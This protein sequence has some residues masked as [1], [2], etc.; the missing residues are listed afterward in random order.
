MRLDKFLTEMN[1]GSRSE[2]KLLLKKK[3]V[4]V[5]QITVTKPE[6]KV[7]PD[8]DVITYQNKVLS[9]EKY[10]YFMLHKPAG[11]VSATDDNTCETVIDL[12]KAEPY[13]NL[14]P[15][16]RLDKDTEGLLLIT[17]DGKFAHELLSPK[18][19]VTKCYYAVIDKPVT[20]IE[21]AAFQQGIDINDEKVTLPAELKAL[22]EEEN[23]QYLAK[24]D[25]ACFQSLHGF[26]TLVT[27][28][29]GR[30]HQVKRMFAAFQQEV[31]YLK[32]ISMGELALDDTLP[33]GAYRRLDSKELLQVKSK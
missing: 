28:T 2:V 6:T 30:F 33:T 17:N 15:V 1:I 9:Y 5:N 3:Q 29:E 21:I 31:L 22:T 18:K 11:Y 12:L 14:F 32:R 23:K 10:V 19:H 25:T 20:E 7:N 4:Q 13:K 24:I 8:T 27:I 16:G 26:G